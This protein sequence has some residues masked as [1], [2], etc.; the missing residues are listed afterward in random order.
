MLPLGV[1]RLEDERRG[2]GLLNDIYPRVGGLGE[3]LQQRLRRLGQEGHGAA[4]AAT[5]MEKVRNGPN[6]CNKSSR[7]VNRGRS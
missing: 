4:H 7:G 2:T 5:M 1:G 6:N 3:A